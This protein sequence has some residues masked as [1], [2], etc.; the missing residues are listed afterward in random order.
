MS[1]LS[2]LNLVKVTIFAPD[3][4]VRAEPLALISEDQIR[5][6]DVSIHVEPGDEIRRPL[7][8]GRDEVFDVLDVRYSEG[9]RTI[10]PSYIIKVARRGSLIH[11]SPQAITVSGPNARVTFGN[12]AS[13]NISH[14]G[15]IVQ[16]VVDAVEAQVDNA[17]S[18]A[19]LISALQE[20]KAAS[21]PASRLAAYQKLVAGAA[22]HMT[23][24]APFLP[25][26]TNLLG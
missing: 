10:P 8:N 1:L 21:E 23:V 5:T 4:L 26:L 22:N 13:T 2:R 11:K 12:D 17:E 9:L 14:Q 15:D 16:Q 24:L 6:E 3:G 7:P 25:A 20:L 19:A 18:R